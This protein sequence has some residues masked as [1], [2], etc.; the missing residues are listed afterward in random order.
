VFS[1][2]IFQ[3]FPHQN[4]V[5]ISYL[6]SILS[7][8]PSSC[9]LLCFTITTVLEGLYKSYVHFSTHI[10]RCTGMVAMNLGLLMEVFQSFLIFSTRWMEVSGYC[11]AMVALPMGMEPLVAIV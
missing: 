11:H 6:F 10:D 1:K 7:T 5:Y 3:G 8:C 2:E 4:S 9:S